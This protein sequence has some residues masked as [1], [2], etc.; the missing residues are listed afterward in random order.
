MNIM[1]LSCG[2]RFKDEQEAIAH[3]EEWKKKSEDSLAYGEGHIWP[4]TVQIAGV[5][6]YMG[7][8][9]K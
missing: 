1:C 2:Q 6:G 3:N 8:T 7:A 4:H 5:A 9:I